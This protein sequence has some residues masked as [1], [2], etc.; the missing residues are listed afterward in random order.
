MRKSA[1]GLA[2][3]VPAAGLT[4]TSAL[5]ARPAPPDAA[6]AQPQRMV[7]DDLPNPEEAKRRE[8]RETALQK[9]LAGKATVQKRGASQVVKVGRT[10]GTEAQPAQD[11]YVERGREKPDKIFV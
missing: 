6:T 1:A 10:K 3:L 7:L 9:L 2:G 8:L 4:T 11:Q 5:T